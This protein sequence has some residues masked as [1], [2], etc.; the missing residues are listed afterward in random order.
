MDVAG[1]AGGRESP[2]APGGPIATRQGTGPG[3]PDLELRHGAR[4]PS[5]QSL[6]RRRLRRTLLA[7]AA[8]AWTA[9]AAIAIGGGVAVSLAGIRFRAQRPVT[10]FLVGLGCAAA[11]LAI[12][13]LAGLREDSEQLW[14][15]RGRVA[16]LT[17][18][19]A[20]ALT[21]VAG[22]AWGTWAASGADAYGYVS[23]AS[24]WAHG[25]LI[26]PQDLAADAPWPSPEQTLSPLGWRPAQEAGAIVPTYAP[27]LPMIMALA[28]LAG[29]SAVFWIVPLAGAATVWLTWRLGRRLADP[30]AAGAAAV[31]MACSPVFLFQTVQPMSDVPVTACW[32]GALLLILAGRPAVA[33]ACASAAILTRPN[34]APLAA[35]IAL[36]PVLL[37]APSGAFV[38]RAARLRRTGV[39]VAALTPGVI[40]WLALNW[41]WYGHPLVSG[42]GAAG[43]L[44]SLSTIGTNAARYAEWLVGTQT[45]FILIGLVSPFVVWL[46]ARR[47]ARALRDAPAAPDGRD[48]EPAGAGLAGTHAYALVYAG[49]VALGY[50]PYASFE[51]WSYLRFLLP[52]FPVLLVTSC[53][54]ALEL[55]RRLPAVARGPALALGVALLAS[56][57]LTGARDGHV[58][59][60][61]RLER[62]YVEAG[63]W[64]GRALPETAVFLAV[65]QSGSLRYY[66]GRPT[67]RWDALDP[68]WLDR[69]LAH[70]RRRGHEPYFVLEAWEEEQFRQH[71]SGASSLGEL[72]WPPAAEIAGPTRVRFYDP[73]DRAKFAAGEHVSTTRV[74]P[75]RTP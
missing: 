15:A 53:T 22:L 23:Q 47:A 70:L 18:A 40:V 8:I 10:A 12:G 43:D 51:D 36:G 19:L 54:V 44:Y 37:A 11:A 20:A 60:L 52:A 34:L 46:A 75:A 72:D 50:L 49:L 64:A 55:L 74:W 42:Y 28:S 6:L 5:N 58:F 63:R 65:Q 67:L 3:Q 59:D 17:A 35:W 31:L 14:R 13:R 71:L 61:H 33:G 66:A 24:A 26:V 27:G 69:A 4:V 32:T 1:E 30:A 29:A 38:P 25:Q 16:A 68:A 45:P 21:A 73:R 2:P 41:R 62:R 57:E 56:I 7:S 39:F 9:S 48:A